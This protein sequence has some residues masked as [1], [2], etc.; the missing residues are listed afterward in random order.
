MKA[1]VFADAGKM[2][3]KDVQEPKL[4]EPYGAI[5]KPLIISPCI[6]RRSL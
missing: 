4:S 3:W 5:L 6:F 1:Y 2:V